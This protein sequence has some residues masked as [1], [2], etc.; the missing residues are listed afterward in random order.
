MHEFVVYFSAFAWLKHY[1]EMSLS[2][3]KSDRIDLPN[4][5]KDWLEYFALMNTHIVK[6]VKV[7]VHITTVDCEI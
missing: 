1:K 5:A 7:I 6:D 2:S 3:Y 4:E